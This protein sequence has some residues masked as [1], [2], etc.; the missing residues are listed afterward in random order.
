MCTD[1]GGPHK[2]L[3]LYNLAVKRAADVGIDV[4]KD[5]NARAYFKNDEVSVKVKGDHG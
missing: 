4:S 3:E 1:A 5:G 2:L